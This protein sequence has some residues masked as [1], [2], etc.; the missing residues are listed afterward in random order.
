LPKAKEKIPQV[1]IPRDL[2]P[3]HSIIPKEGI[4]NTKKKA[5][6]DLNGTPRL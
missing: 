4:L 3:N 5:S 6:Y 1:L 2:N